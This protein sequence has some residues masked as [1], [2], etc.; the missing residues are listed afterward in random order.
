M[1]SLCLIY[2]EIDERRTKKMKISDHPILGKKEEKKKV[3]IIFEG[4]NIEAE[5]GDPVAV[6]LMNAGIRDFRLTRKKGEPRGVY[7]AIGRCTD[8]MMTI[9][10]RANVRTCITPVEE[11]MIVE[12]GKLS[13]EGK[14][15]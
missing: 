12:R 4:K 14:T 8:C 2:Y 7:C 3:M 1:K 13:R 6:A 11:G 5:E 15:K 10:G 9:N